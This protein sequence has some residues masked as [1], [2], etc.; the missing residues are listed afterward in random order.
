MR[1]FRSLSDL[2]VRRG[3]GLLMFPFSPILQMR[4]LKSREGKQ[5]TRSHIARYKRAGHPQPLPTPW[6]LL[7]PPKGEGKQQAGWERKG[8]APWKGRPHTLTSEGASG[9]L[10]CCGCPVSTLPLLILSS[11]LHFCW[12]RSSCFSVLS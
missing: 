2:S 4:K 7:P 9:P 1:P 6:G 10:Q 5:Q 8:G 12:P 3:T 11:R